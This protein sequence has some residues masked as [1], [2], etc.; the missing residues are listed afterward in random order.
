MKKLLLFSV[1]ICTGLFSQ[2][3]INN[4]DFENWSQNTVGSTTYD[5]LH[6]WMTY[7][8]LVF[9][10]ADAY[11]F[12]TIL[13]SEGAFQEQ[14]GSGGVGSALRLETVDC[15][16][17]PQA[18]LPTTIPAFA[19][20]NNTYTQRPESISFNY[21]YEPVNGDWGAAAFLLTSGTGALMDT[22]AGVII[23]F[24]NAQS[25]WTNMTFPLSY[26][27]AAN[28]D[29]IRVSLLSSG[30]TLLNNL[31]NNV[32]PAEVGSKLYVDDIQ[33]NMPTPGTAS[34]VGNILANDIA[35]NANGLDL[36]VQ[37]NAGMDETTIGEYRIF[38]V[39]EANAAAFDLTAAQAITTPDYYSQMPMGINFYQGP[40][41]A[42]STDTDGDLIVENQPYRIFILS[43]ADGTNATI[44]NL[45]PM[46]NSVTLMPSPAVAPNQVIAADIADNNNGLDLDVYFPQSAD[47]STVGE[48][49]VMVV[50][51]ANAGSFDVTAGGT[52]APADYTVIAPTGAAN[53][54]TVLSATATDVD[55]DLIVINQPYKVFIYVEA[56]G[57]N[58]GFD[59]ISPESIEVTLVNSVG[60]EDN[61]LANIKFYPN[62][63]KETLTIQT[64]LTT[65]Q[66]TVFGLDGKQLISVQM[67][68]NTTVNVA[69]WAKGTYIFKIEN[70]DVVKTQK[71][72]VQ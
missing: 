40:F 16:L 30:D 47:E 9:P 66:L 46:S 34:P 55:G 23:P 25:S 61:T 5:S 69:D 37:F 10:L 62:P 45:S 27:S 39:K 48:Y 29:S 50:K 17:C 44:D 65:Y 3:Q 2:A 22:I 26:F 20:F 70:N 19:F 54:Q 71:V 43:V 11:G 21:K 51:S 8:D 14:P 67:N 42:A 72:I 7:N 6:H 28:P 31:Y 52:V 18:G 36:G 15:Q 63:V 58:A 59:A 12:P 4:A 13:F 68:N 41:T 53:Y 32:P 49:R 56:D 57:V 38:A 60:I 1:L 35:N 24:E 64:K 33:L